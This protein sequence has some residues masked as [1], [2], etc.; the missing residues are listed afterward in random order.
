MDGILRMGNV[1][2]V[3]GWAGLIKEDWEDVSQGIDGYPALD[4]QGNYLIAG[5]NDK[6]FKAS[7]IQ[8]NKINI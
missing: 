4:E 1:G 3:K 6:K 5:G 7:R 8:Y 2:P